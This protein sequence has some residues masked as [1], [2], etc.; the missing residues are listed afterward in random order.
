[1]PDL[2]TAPY[3]SLKTLRQEIVPWSPG[4]SPR[5][6]PFQQ[7][8]NQDEVLRYLAM[9]DEREYFRMERAEAV[10]A[11]CLARRRRRLLAD[12]W[13]LKQ[14]SAK[15]AARELYDFGVRFLREIKNFPVALQR[16]HDARFVGWRPMERIWSFDDTYKGRPAW[17]VE[18]LR[19]K[20][21]H[22]F[23]FT[24]NRSLVYSGDLEKGE[25]V[26]DFSRDVDRLRWMICAA[27]S[28]D[29]PYGEAELG[30]VWMPFYLKG[31]FMR[32]WA[33][34]IQRSLGV[35]TAR[36][37][38]AAAMS[39]ISDR[40][41]STAGG[42]PGA[43]ETMQ[44]IGLELQS[45]LKMM[46]DSGVLIQRFGWEVGLLGDV[47]YA[48]GWKEPLAYCDR[49]ICL[50]LTGDTLSLS[51]G[52]VGSRGAMETVSDQ[53][54]Q[55]VMADGLEVAGWINNQLL[56]D[57]FQLNV[58][59]PDPDDVP[60]FEFRVGRNMN[61]DIARFL[62]NG[63]VALDA[64]EIAAEGG[65]PLLIDPQPGD[66]VMQKQQAVIGPDGKPIAP[67]G[68]GTKPATPSGPADKAKAGTPP[69]KPADSG[70]DGAKP[71]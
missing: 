63:G 44:E 57:A 66:V 56:K 52:Q 58:P 65:V 16:M 31:E 12:G 67:Q 71:N 20:P 51:A 18:H 62:F 14:A 55:Y 45:T 8:P 69:A 38:G 15:P 7:I 68:A 6:D 50:A 64:R 37:T 21:P 19:E 3:N 1:M 36:Q 27:G 40:R 24:A 70:T 2:R 60:T 47:D 48:D 39:T 59:D 49:L 46:Q 9:K 11:H 22:L 42:G 5:T 33:Q 28:T 26:F 43:A 61:L 35:V 4:L 10:I 54:E 13:R 32:L 17:Y 34:G 53:L 29:N 41:A 30:K 25:Q 23:R